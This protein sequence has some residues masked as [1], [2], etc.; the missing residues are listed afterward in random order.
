MPL[1]TILLP[2]NV[3]SFFKALIN[4]VSMDFFDLSPKLQA[5]YRL[6]EDSTYEAYN[7]RFDL[8]GY[9]TTNTIYNL[10]MPMFYLMWYV[11][12]GALYGVL[13]CVKLCLDKNET[14]SEF[15]IRAKSANDWVLRKLRG[16]LFWA[17]IMRFVVELALEG[18]ISAII[19]IWASPGVTEWGYGEV[20]TSMISVFLIISNIALVPIFSYVMIKNRSDF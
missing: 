15:V 7:D 4:V 3:M 5:I 11:A 1:F 2:P 8:L 18:V 13:K 20:M 14:P 10:G 12:S 17:P 9:S 16:T 19:N 6:P